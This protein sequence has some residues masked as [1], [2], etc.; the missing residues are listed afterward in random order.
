MEAGWVVVVGVLLL[1]DLSEGGLE[2]FDVA[3]QPC[4]DFVG[5]GFTDEVF[6]G[7]LVIDFNKSLVVVGFKCGDD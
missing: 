4:L 1:A 3:S 6:L 7:D 2:V 5:K